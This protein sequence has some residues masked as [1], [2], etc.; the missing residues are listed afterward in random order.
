MMKLMEMIAK[1]TT[2]EH[3]YELGRMVSELDIYC[4]GR[5]QEDSQ[6]P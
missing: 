3:D 2:K 5:G 4:A 1:S 6:P